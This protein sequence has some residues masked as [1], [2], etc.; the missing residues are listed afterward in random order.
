MAGIVLENVSK[1]YPGGGKAVIDFNLEI[2]DKEF[3]VLVGPSG[4]GKSTTLRM[5][6]GLEECTSG[7]IYI[8][9]ECMN[10]V[11]PK[12]RDIAMVF[13]SYALYRHMTVYD[14]MAFG[15]KIKKVPKKEI[16]R[17]VREIAEILGLTDKL[18]K[19]PSAMSGGEC[20]R[21]ALG[22]ALVR[23]PRVFLFDEPLSNL[24]A[25]LRTQMRSE[26]IRLHE[27]VQTTFVY[28]THDQTE[29]MTMGDRIVV[30]DHGVIQQAASPREIYDRP[31]NMFTAGFIGTPQI[32]FFKANEIGAS[33]SSDVIV[34]IRPEDLHLAPCDGAVIGSGN[35]EFIELLG[36]SMNVH[37]SM[38]GHNVIMTCPVDNSIARGNTYEIWAEKGKSRLFDASTG[39]AI[40]SKT[41]AE[42]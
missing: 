28:V 22:R 35:V 40:A 11:E 13:Q 32:N 8:G 15:L 33:G 26:I 25:K 39:L 36:A 6:A 37:L 23:Q 20:Q 5:I 30:M 42:A 4:C 1:T 34:G 27:N 16:D 17:R 21:V 29:A 31:A 14:N 10:G 2:A 38:N 9:G 7:R 41:E 12:D 24:D 19:K 3:V 18:K